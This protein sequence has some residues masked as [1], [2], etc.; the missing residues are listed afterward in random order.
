MKWAPGQSPPW[1]LDLELHWHPRTPVWPPLGITTAFLPRCNHCSD[2]GDFYFLA[3][4]YNFTTNC[5]ITKQCSLVVSPAF[6]FLNL[7]SMESY[8]NDALVSCFF[9]SSL[10]VSFT[11]V[12][13]CN[14]ILSFLLYKSLLIFNDSF[15]LRHYAVWY[16][17]SSISFL[18]ILAWE[19][20][21]H[22]FGWIFVL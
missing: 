17:Y 5:G 9:H 12:F 13:A 10:R 14:C 15:C 18:S 7:M 2:F 3:F 4:L 8:C 19:V 6:V 1:P 11:H 22:P 16:G 21:F 20:F